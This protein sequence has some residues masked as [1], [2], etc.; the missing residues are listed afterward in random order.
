MA[1]DGSL[2]QCGQL[3]C[4]GK[5]PRDIAIDPSGGYLLVANQGSDEI[6]LFELDLRSG[7]PLAVPVKISIPSPACIVY[8]PDRPNLSV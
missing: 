5:K 2:L 4:G 7:M 6:C 3:N 1:V 8:V